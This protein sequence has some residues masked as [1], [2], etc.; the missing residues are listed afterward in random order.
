[1]K[2]P[3]AETVKKNQE[4][5]A[6]AGVSLERASLAFKRLGKSCAPM[7]AIIK[8]FEKATR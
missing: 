2:M 8:N 1:M 7:A 5:L 3:T 4:G 6:K